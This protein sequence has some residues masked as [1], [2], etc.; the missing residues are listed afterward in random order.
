MSDSPLIIIILVLM[1]LTA[2][3]MTMM[4]IMALTAML[5]GVLWVMIAPIL[6]DGSE[7]LLIRCFLPLIHILYRV[8]RCYR[9]G[10]A[11]ARKHVSIRYDTT[12]G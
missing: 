7:S 6:V 1:V 9:E 2:M 3:K 10:I 8:L 11:T 12:R 5:I 4:A